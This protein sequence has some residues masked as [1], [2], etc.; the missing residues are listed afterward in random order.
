M[1]RLTF[2]CQQCGTTVRREMP[3]GRSGAPQGGQVLCPK[4]HGKMSLKTPKAK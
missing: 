2:V 4:G 3:G 1:M